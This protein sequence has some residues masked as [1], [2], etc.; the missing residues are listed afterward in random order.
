MFTDD[1]TADGARTAARKILSDDD[2][3]ADAEKRG[4]KL[5]AAGGVD[6]MVRTM[7]AIQMIYGGSKHKEP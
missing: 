5:I 3:R 6:E 7:T 1:F 4:K 2:T